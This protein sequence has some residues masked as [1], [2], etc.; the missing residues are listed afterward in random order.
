MLESHGTV[1]KNTLYSDTKLNRKGGNKLRTY[2]KFKSIL[3]MESYLTH[4]TNRDDRKTLCQIRTSSH[5]LSIE[6][7]RHLK[8]PEC[9]RLCQMC[10]AMHIEDELHFVIQCPAYQHLR[11][12]LLDGLRNVHFQTY[13]DEDKFIWLMSNED[14]D[15]C[16]KL[17]NFI[18][19]AYNLRLG[20][21]C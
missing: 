7:G 4:V 14:E 3:Q 5:K 15:I 13:T 6:T 19:A 1:W 21:S 11:S 12:P 2:R 9:K 18:R 8:I 16:R 20:I 17:A 10:Q